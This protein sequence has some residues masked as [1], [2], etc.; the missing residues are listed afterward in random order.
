[1]HFEIHPFQYHS[2]QF[3]V[4]MYIETQLELDLHLMIVN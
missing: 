3:H 2:V 1:M 4:E